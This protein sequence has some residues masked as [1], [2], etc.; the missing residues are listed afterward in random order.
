MRKKF[1]NIEND[2]EFKNF[3]LE[4][5]LP[6]MNRREPKAKTSEPGQ[7]PATEETVL[8]PPLDEPDTSSI[9][10]AVSQAI[11]QD[12]P[13][14]WK[15]DSDDA[16]EEVEAAV[17]K[18]DAP[19]ERTIIRRISSKQ[20]RLSLDE[21]RPTYLQVPKIVD[22]KPVFVSREVRDGLDRIVRCLGGRGM[23]V[24]GLVENLAR[25]HLA[26]YGNDIDQW[27]KL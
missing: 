16:D 6:S 24:S 25:Q 14:V 8:F 15:T 1:K 2:E 5:Y 19:A 9:Q 18:T 10:E 7:E 20:R 22:R 12:E 3:K 21:Y 26:A 4:D 27:R 13:E 17:T 23:S 11:R